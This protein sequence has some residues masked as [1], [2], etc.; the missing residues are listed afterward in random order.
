MTERA[1]IYA[2]ISEDPRQTELGVTR[3]RKDCASLV[4]LRGWKLVETF[5]DNDIAALK[6]NATRP[7]YAA[8][9]AAVERGQVT[10]IVAF[11]LSRLWRN[12]RERADAIEV[13]R[14]YRVS[15]SLVKG[16]D[17]D[18]TSA[19][20]RGVAGL[21]GEFDTMESEVKAERVASAALQRAEQGRANGH[22]AYGWRRVRIRNGEGDVVDLIGTM[23]STRRRPRSSARSWTDCSGSSRSARSSPT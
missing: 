21:M 19:A 10:R 17:L 14:R 7:G 18:M 1:A 20:G 11:G 22:V 4:E 16:S 23:K 3:Q 8:L 6:G 12:R 9:M 13:L 5:T 2:R 15:V